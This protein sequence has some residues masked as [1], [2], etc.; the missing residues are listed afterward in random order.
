ME[1]YTA[2]VQE[3]ATSSKISRS[4]V[5]VSPKGKHQLLLYTELTISDGLT[6]PSRMPYLMKIVESHTAKPLPY[7][8]LHVLSR[9]IESH[10]PCGYTIIQVKFIHSCIHIDTFMYSHIHA[11]TCICTTSIYTWLHQSPRVCPDNDPSA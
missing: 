2:P 6:K 4:K 5:D 11:C 3:M 7:P 10:T 8:I 9:S 1:E